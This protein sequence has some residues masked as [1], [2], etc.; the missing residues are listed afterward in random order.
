MVSTADN[1][2]LYLILIVLCR[3]SIRM[4]GIL[5]VHNRRIW[6]DVNPQSTIQSRHQQQFSTFRL[7][8]LGTVS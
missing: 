4:T 6:S 2:E 8:L 3:V 5:N 7:V 1:V